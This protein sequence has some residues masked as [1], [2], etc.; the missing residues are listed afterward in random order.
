MFIVEKYKDFEEKEWD[1]FVLNDSVNG[2]FL[3]TRRFLN[4]HPK[5]RFEDNSLIIKDKK[6]TI[7]AVCPACNIKENGYKVFYSHKGSTF[8]G[9]IIRRK[10]YI[11]NKVLEM[12]DLIDQ[13]LGDKNY[14]E[15]TLKITPSLFSKES[16]ELLEYCLENRNY[17]EYAELST[18]IDYY[19]YKEKITSNFTQGKRT[20]VNNGIKEGLS[21]QRLNDDDKIRNF[22][23]ILCQNLHKYKTNPVHSIEELLEFKNSSLKDICQFYGV[24]KENEMIAGGMVFYFEQTNVAHTQYLAAKEEYA[25][26]SPSTFLYYGIIKEMKEKNICKL[27]W[28]ISTED[29][30]KILNEGLIK[31]KEAYGSKYSLNRTFYKSLA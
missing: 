16:P 11:S 21:F 31:S 28:G 30:G 2:T 10:Y 12:I 1:D 14:E 26:L 6:G 4:Y 18:Y 19:S 5:N 13:Y 3:Q 17:N 8:G 7:A 22:Y 23:E 27:S 20:N 29:K 9:I 24:F 25:T 15:I